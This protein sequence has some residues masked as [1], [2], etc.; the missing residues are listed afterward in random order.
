MHC[1]KSQG[2]AFSY[3]AGALPAGGE[4]GIQDEQPAGMHAISFDY[5]ATAQS[6]SQAAA[7]QVH[8]EA[9]E[10]A[11]QPDFAIPEHLADVPETLRMHK[12]SSHFVC[13]ECWWFGV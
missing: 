9:P 11:F 6:Q 1:P 13:C 8:A 5:G 3:S 10:E 12:V 2:C 7:A 4:A